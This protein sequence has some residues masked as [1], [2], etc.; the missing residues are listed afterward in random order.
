MKKL[1]L[2]IVF[3]LLSSIGYGQT[4]SIPDAAFLSFL[5][6]NYSQTINS[7]DELIISAA[8]QVTGTI[9]CPSLGITNLEGIQYF[10]QITKISAIHNSIVSLPSLL[11]ITSLQTLHIYDNKIANAPDFRGMVNLKIVLLYQNNLTQMPL[12]GNNPIIEEIIISQNNISTIPSLSEVPSLLKLDIGQNQLS[13]LPDL[14]ANVNLQELICWSNKLTVLPSLKNLVNLTRLNAGK[15]RLTVFPDLSANT[16]LSILALDNNLLTSIPPKIIGSANF[17]AVKLYNNYFTFQD[18]GPYAGIL[19]SSNVYTYIPMLPVVGDTIDTY[20]NESVVLHSHVD[21]IVANVTYNWYEGVAN[22]GS[23]LDDAVTIKQV[24]GTGITKRYIYAKITH[25]SLTSLTL[26][27]DTFLVR[28]N[29]CPTSADVTYIPEKKDC[30]NSGAIQVAVQGY[31]SPQTSYM[32]TSTSFGTTEYSTINKFKG[33]IDTA[34]ILHV[35]FAATCVLDYNKSLKMPT[36]D[37]NEAFMTPNNDGDMDTYFFPGKGTVIIY[38]KYGKEVKRA[39][40]PYDWDGSGNSGLVQPGYYIGVMN[41]G[42]DRV[43]ISV[44]Y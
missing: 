35:D 44:L 17:T 37:C 14:S 10:S 36:A 13:K 7:S 27:T 34:Y 41:G 43:N 16:Q 1:I 8:A 23:G 25:P 18:L 19:T 32:L 9:A 21:T 31:V 28:F 20:Y 5:K 24:G 29:P 38:D 39:S 33:L 42:K 4:V 15:N 30:G 22:I 11:P 2:Y 26:V 12:F 3:I 6:A 40:L